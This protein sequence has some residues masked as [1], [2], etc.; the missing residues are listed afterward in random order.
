MESPR[1]TTRLRRKTFIKRSLS[2]GGK[3]NDLFAAIVD[4][5]RKAAFSALS[6]SSKVSRGMLSFR[7]WH[8]ISPGSI[9]ASGDEFAPL[10][11]S[12]DDVFAPLVAWGLLP[13][14][15]RGFMADRQSDTRK[16][17]PHNWSSDIRC[18]WYWCVWRPA[19]CFLHLG[20]GMVLLSGIVVARQ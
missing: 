14:S 5:G 7:Y 19:V 3:L 17:K 16:N 20:C 6:R 15:L 2:R 10:V 8:A 18:L 4:H 13:D 12:S 1:N 11:A 9:L